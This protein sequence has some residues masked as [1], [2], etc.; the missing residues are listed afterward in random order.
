MRPHLQLHGATPTAP[1]LQPAGGVNLTKID[2]SHGIAQLAPLE[3]AMAQHARQA[4]GPSASPMKRSPH[5]RQPRY[6]PL[7][8]VFARARGRVGGGYE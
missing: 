8:F 1:L 3:A 2:I 4:A 6:V 7:S 5:T